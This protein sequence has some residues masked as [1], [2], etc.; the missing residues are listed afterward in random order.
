VRDEAHRFAVGY[1]RNLRGRRMV[2]SV[3]DGVAG[4]GPARKR[5][6][7]RRF[8]S[9]TK[10]REAT[11]EELSHLVPAGVAEAVHTALHTPMTGRRAVGSAPD[12]EE[13]DGA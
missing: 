4:V 7:L 12:D 8:G 11:V 2:D 1:H 10:L 6:L 13:A 9:L 5:L 3:L